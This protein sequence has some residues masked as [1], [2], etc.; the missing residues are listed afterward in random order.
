MVSGIVQ[1]HPFRK[2]ELADEV[3]RA[4]GM[5]CSVPRR[6]KDHARVPLVLAVVENAIGDSRGKVERSNR[7]GLDGHFAQVDLYAVG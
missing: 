6:S 7:T 3:G 5:F 2:K 4:V 1:T